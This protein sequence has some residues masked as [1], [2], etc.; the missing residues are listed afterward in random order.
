MEN[1]VT[2][3]RLI[4]TLGGASWASESAAINVPGSG[5]TEKRISVNP[6]LC[7][8]VGTNRGGYAGDRVY[9]YSQVLVLS[10]YK[11]L[12]HRFRS[13]TVLVLREIR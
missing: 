1:V 9:F 10:K 8:L 2:I 12:N 4:H 11:Y 6:R 13:S 5:L 3:T 7:A